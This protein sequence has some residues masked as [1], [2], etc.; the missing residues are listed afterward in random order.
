VATGYEETPVENPRGV[1]AD[2]LIELEALL[3]RTLDGYEGWF[4]PELRGPLRSAWAELGESFPMADRYLREPPD[5][6]LLDA[7]LAHVGLAGNQLRLKVGAFRGKLAGL[8]ELITKP[9]LKSALG[10]ANII[11]GSLSGIVP[12][13]EAIKEYK[14]SFEQALDDANADNSQGEQAEG[15]KKPRGGHFKL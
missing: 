2:F 10:W 7:Q 11:L 8:G 4:P 3:P 6:V 12:G 1:L 14:E 15:P 9:M 5:A 13:V